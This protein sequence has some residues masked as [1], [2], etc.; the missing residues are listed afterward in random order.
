LK[1]E[2]RQ[3]SSS[4]SGLPRVRRPNTNSGE[5][6]KPKAHVTFTTHNYSDDEEDDVEEHPV[7]RRSD[8]IVRSPL[9]HHYHHGTQQPHHVPVSPAPPSMIHRPTQKSALR[10]GLSSSAPKFLQKSLSQD[11][12]VPPKV[13]ITNAVSKDLTKPSSNSTEHCL[14]DE[15]SADTPSS[16][17]EVAPSSNPTSHFI[18]TTP[19][20]RTPRTPDLDMTS[21]RHNQSSTSL[22]HA[23]DQGTGPAIPLATS[24]QGKLTRTQQKLLLQRASTQPPHPLNLASTTSY[25]SPSVAA[26]QHVESAPDYFSPIPSAQQMLTPAAVNMTYDVKVAREYERISRE[27]ANAKRFGNPIADA[28]SRLRARAQP[29]SNPSLA[30]KSSAFGLSM[31]WKRSP[32]KLGERRETNTAALFDDEGRSKLREAMRRMWFDGVDVREIGCGFVD[33]DDADGDGEDDL[34]LNG[35]SDARNRRG[36][37]R[38]R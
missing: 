7:R 12:L 9:P 10:E 22:G 25:S 14:P 3:S 21:L 29:A 11:A 20:S 8:E 4:V 19:P 15:P 31:T 17:P 33:S 23:L 5:K 6:P 36:S 1:K 32:D 28:I 30:K 27:L 38:S 37:G 34:R 16:A 13:S 2:R 35:K 24:S 18:T 26:T